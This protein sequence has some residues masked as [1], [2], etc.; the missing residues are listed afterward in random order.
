MFGRK[1]KRIQELEECLNQGE[2]QYQ[3]L[4]WQYKEVR[5][6]L[7]SHG[8]EQAWNLD[9]I[10]QD[11]RAQHETQKEETASLVADTQQRL[12]QLEADAQQR[13]AQLEITHQETVERL[14][15][16]EEVLQEKLRPMRVQV[17]LEEAGFTDYAH[18]AKDSVELGLELRD[19]RKDVQMSVRNYSAV[20][21]LEE[22]QVPATKAQRNKVARDTAKLALTAFNS[23]VDTIVSGATIRNHESSLAKI[24]K[25]ADTVE[26]LG[27][28][29]GVKISPDYI[30]QRIRELELAIRYHEAKALEKELER[31]RRAE[32]REQARAEK[33]LQAEKERLEKERQ[34]YLNVLNTVRESGDSAEI[35]KLEAKLQDIENGLN[36]VEQRNANIRAGYVYVISNLGAFGPN[37]VKIGMTRRLEPMDRV[38]ELGDASVPFRFDVHALF[39]SEDAVGVE[40]EL[41]RRFADKRVNRINLRRE[42][43]YATPLEVKKELAGIAGNLLEFVDEPEAEQY[44][45]S[46]EMGS[47]DD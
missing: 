24:V 13:L 15:K 2:R 19:L 25:V 30:E 40:A 26:R 3:E 27:A 11:L 41:H 21:S 38:R 44:R 43:F 18:P 42:F 12:A 14:A 31:E 46:L 28:S 4:Q 32:L 39:F 6:F 47:Q 22:I 36:D 7:D 23:Q 33:E 9:K 1:S 37:V 29:S 35:A 34:H 16:E 10:L 45:L 17:K 5:T 8:G 20:S